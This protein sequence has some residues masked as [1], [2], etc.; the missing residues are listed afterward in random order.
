MAALQAQTKLSSSEPGV[1]PPDL[2]GA[3]TANK[4]HKDPR[5]WHWPSPCLPTILPPPLPSQRR[6]SS[7]FR[8]HVSGTVVTTVA[9]LF[10]ILI[11]E[12][13]VNWRLWNHGWVQIKLSPVS[14]LLQPRTPRPPL[15][16]SFKMIRACLSNSTALF[17]PGELR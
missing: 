13:S 6:G 14:I 16:K 11:P 9:S 15:P 12:T 2:R 3:A 8:T 7:L 4:T 10:L 17:L 1:C 5:H